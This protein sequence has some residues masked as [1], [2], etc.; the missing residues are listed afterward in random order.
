MNE[1]TSKISAELLVSNTID[2]KI[3]S[4]Q[5]SI[6]PDLEGA[7]IIILLIIL[8][9]V[10]GGIYYLSSMTFRDMVTK[11][12]PLAVITAIAVSIIGGIAIATS[13]DDK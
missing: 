11:P 3:K 13:S 1:A 9:I 7:G 12:I 2:S 10:G 8:V 5:A 4:E 6:L